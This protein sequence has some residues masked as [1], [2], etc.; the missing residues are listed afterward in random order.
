[1]K[2]IIT[3]GTGLIGSALAEYLVKENHKVVVLS[4]NPQKSKRRSAQAIIVEKWDGLTASGWGHHVDGADVIVN[5]A[6]ESIAGESFLDLIFKRWTPER[7]QHI[8]QSR[9]DAGKAIFEAVSAANLK[10]R[11]LIQ[12]SAVGYYGTRGDE[13][14]TEDS[15]QGED[16]LSE[17]CKKWEDSTAQVEELGIC[18]VII[19]TGGVVLSTKGGAFPFMLL[20]FNMFVGGPLGRG[21]QWF[22]W[23]HMLDEI[24]AI[25][26]LIN[27]A[28]AHGVFNLV[29]PQVVTNKE[30]SKIMGKVIRRPSYFPVP[31]MILRLAFGQKADFLLG[32]QRQVPKRLLSLGFEFMFP[33]P[34]SALQ[35]LLG[36]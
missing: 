34:E 30:F 10:P 22:A 19:R 35:N 3:G 32:S 25:H 1:M 33:D 21:N 23:I 16:Y 13:E 26:F 9:L 12:A 17:V 11:V 27:N 7:K 20:P 29:A 5:L 2:V 14:I 24:R 8:L 15:P 4:R 6:G 36:K 28:N 18:R 31:A